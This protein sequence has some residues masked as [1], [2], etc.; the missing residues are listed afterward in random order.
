[1]KPINLNNIEEKNVGGGDF[2]QLK[3]GAYACKVTEVIDN[4]DREYLDVLLDIC[5]GEFEGY[6]SDKFYADKPWS[7]H[8]ILSYKDALENRIQGTSRAGGAGGDRFP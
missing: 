7:H 1:M 2:P 5:V 4:A 6:F 3:P 8:V